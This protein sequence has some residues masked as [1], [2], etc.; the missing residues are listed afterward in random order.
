MQKKTAPWL[1]NHPKVRSVN[2]ATLKDSP[3]HALAQKI[4][5][6]KASGILSFEL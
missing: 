4:T 5:Q 3:Y 2:Y 1:A 6:G